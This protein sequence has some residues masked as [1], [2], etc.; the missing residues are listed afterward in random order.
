MK[1]FVEGE[2]L[3]AADVN[4]ELNPNVAP[5]IPYG[6]AVLSAT[7]QFSASATATATIPLPAG[8]FSRGPAGFVILV[9]GG[10]RFATPR[11]VTSGAT[12]MQIELRTADNSSISLTVTGFVLAIQMQAGSS[13]G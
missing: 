1:T 2:I 9:S 6:M 11:Y 7:W 4:N 10:V 5:N 3:T 13:T 12:S 8:R